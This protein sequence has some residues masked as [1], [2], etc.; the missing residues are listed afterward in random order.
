MTIYA[1]RSIVIIVVLYDLGL[2]YILESKRFKTIGGIYTQAWLM[3]I[4]LVLCAMQIIESNNSSQR[5]FFIILA[6]LSSVGLCLLVKSFL[7]KDEGGFFTSKQFYITT[8]EMIFV[9][10]V[11]LIY[12]GIHG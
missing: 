1:V 3:L 10:M 11:S 8:A 4:N 9:L 5:R 6:C 2:S 7:S 12:F